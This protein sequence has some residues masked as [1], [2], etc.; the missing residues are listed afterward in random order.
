MQLIGLLIIVNTLI[1]GAW[2]V[3][4]GRPHSVGAG[5]VCLLAVFAGIVLMVLDRATEISIKGVGT[6]KAAVE[7]VSQDAKQIAE[8]RE[9]IENQSATVNLVAREASEAKKLVQEASQLLAFTTTVVAAQTDDRVAFDKLNAWADDKSD[10]FS[11][12]ALEAWQ[13]IFDEHCEGRYQTNLDK[14]LV[15]P[16]GIDPSKLTLAE[17]GKIYQSAPSNLKPGLIEYIWKRRDDITK[18]DRMQ[19]LI[20]IIQHDGSLKAVEYAG[21]YFAQGMGQPR[22]KPML[23]DYFVKWWEENKDTNQ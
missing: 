11:S 2:W 1:L 23:V 10:P 13:S 6:I 8:I 9:R 15:W 17:L 7:Q 5:F 22:V 20:G 12:R 18:T 19:F 21:R 14:G 4:S 16:Q 3:A